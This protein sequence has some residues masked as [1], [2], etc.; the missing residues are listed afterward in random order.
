MPRMEGRVKAGT[1][2]ASRQYFSVFGHRM[3]IDGKGAGNKPSGIG[4]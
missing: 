4:V 2:I 1:Y 3:V